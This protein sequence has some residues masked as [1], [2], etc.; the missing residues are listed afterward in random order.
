[1]TGHFEARVGNSLYT[2]WNPYFSISGLLGIY[3]Y[4]WGRM[5][6]VRKERGI[7]V[8]GEHRKKRADKNIVRHHISF[9]MTP[10]DIKKYL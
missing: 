1:V 8:K 5:K 6:K 10:E 3:K 2:T 7:N 4:L 9:K